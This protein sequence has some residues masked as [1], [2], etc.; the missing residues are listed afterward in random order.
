MA[1]ARSQATALMW[2]HIRMNT[3]LMSQ[4]N[5]TLEVSAKF[6]ALCKNDCPGLWG[7]CL[8]D[9]PVFKRTGIV[10]GPIGTNVVN[11]GKWVRASAW[12]TIIVSYSGSIKCRCTQLGVPTI[13]DKVPWL[14]Y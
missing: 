7:F 1:N 13:N 4:L 3:D 8:K 12:R 11:L 2:A 6:S 14:D 9:K 10:W 5:D